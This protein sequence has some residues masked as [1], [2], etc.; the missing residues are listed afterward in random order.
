MKNLKLSLLFLTFLTT[1]GFS[2]VI[3]GSGVLA[4]SLEEAKSQ[5]L[6]GETL[7]GYLALVKPN[8]PGEAKSLMNDIN[9]KRKQKYQEIAKRNGTKLPAV[10]ALAGKTAMSKTKSGHYIQLPNKKW[11]QKP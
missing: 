4:M 11:E 8:A 9:Q 3:G 2:I 6:L 1:I 10:E 7:S 5:G